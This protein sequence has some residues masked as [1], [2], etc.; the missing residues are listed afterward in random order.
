VHKRRKNGHLGDMTQPDHRVTD[1]PRVLFRS[2]GFPC[3][4]TLGS[5]LPFEKLDGA[6]VPGDPLQS[7]RAV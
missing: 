4:E 1:F 5:A 2:H 3:N 7:R 6:F